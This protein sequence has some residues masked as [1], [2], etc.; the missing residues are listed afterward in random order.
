[1]KFVENFQ[2]CEFNESETCFFFISNKIFQKLN[3]KKKIII[4]EQIMADCKH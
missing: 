3:V 4:I 2:L 1:M